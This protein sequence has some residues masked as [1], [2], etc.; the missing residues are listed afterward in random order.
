MEM[1]NY[2]SYIGSSTEKKKHIETNHL[3]KEPYLIIIVTF[4]VSD[5][6]ETSD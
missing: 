3:A 4:L 2:L 1:I 6:I 5:S